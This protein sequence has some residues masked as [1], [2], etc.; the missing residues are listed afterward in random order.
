MTPPKTSDVDQNLPEVSVVMPCLNEED[1]LES[2]LRK[3]VDAF[4][5]HGIRGEIIVADNGSSDSSI[6]IA[7]RMGAR[8]INVKKKGYGNALMGGIEAVRSR[9]VIMGDADDS[10]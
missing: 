5:T 2:C 3:A 6:K 9:F 8:V 1:T 4:Q 7:E 10:Y